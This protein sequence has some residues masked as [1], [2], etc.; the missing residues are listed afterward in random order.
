MK[1]EDVETFLNGYGLMSLEFR[2]LTRLGL[3]VHRII[4]SYDSPPGL[5]ALLKEKFSTHDY[6]MRATDRFSVTRS[7]SRYG[8]VTFVNFF[9]KFVNVVLSDIIHLPERDFTDSFKKSRF[10]SFVKHFDWFH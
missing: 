1:C 4:S 5:K 2:I 3:F 8:D 6:G 10:I 7:N 9:S